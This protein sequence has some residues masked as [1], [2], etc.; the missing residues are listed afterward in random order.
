MINILWIRYLLPALLITQFAGL[1]FAQSQEAIRLSDVNESYSFIVPSGFDSKQN[2]EGFALADSGKTT[3]LVVKSHNFQ[4]FQKFAEQSNLEK[5]GFSPVGKVQDF[6]EQNK[7]FRVSKQTSQG[8]LIVD[9]F[10]LFSPFGG[11]ALVVA[12]SNS[13]NAENSFQKALEIVKSVNFTKPRESAV[14]NRI[15]DTLRGKHLLYLHTSSGFSERTDIYLCPSGSFIYRSDSS[16]L[17]ANGSGV[18]AVNSDGNWK[19]LAIGNNARLIL[20]FNSGST[21]EYK[22]SNR[23]ASNEIGLNGNRYFVQNHSQCR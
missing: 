8:L 15:Q 6:G 17:S 7:T 22:I 19:I 1:T 20:Q 5:D 10:V 9:T 14:E 4:T 2:E 18:S 23:Q 21:R 12:F 11:G 13:K 16:S 3:I